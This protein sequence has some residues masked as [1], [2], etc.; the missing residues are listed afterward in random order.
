MGKNFIKFRRKVRTEA[1]ASSLLLG[2]GAG[3]FGYAVMAIVFKL[4]GRTLPTFWYAV[5]GGGAVLT[6]LILYFI[7]TPSDKRL[8]KRLDSVYSL[9]EKI[10]TMVEL[11]E[12]DDGFA[13]LQRE[14]AEEKLGEKPMRALKSKQ[15]IAGILVFAIAAG[16]LTGAVLV[17]AKAEAGEA[18]I[19]A[20]D[21]E[22][23][24]TTLNE[25]IS[26][27]EGS[28]IDDTLKATSLD[29]LRSLLAFVEESQLL[30]EMKAEAI[31][32]V[33]AINRALNTAN[34]AE[35]IGEQLLLSQDKNI[36]SLGKEMQELSGSGS[37]KALLTLGEAI[38]AASVQDASFTAEEIIT[39]IN[40]SGVRADD[41]LALMFK[42]LASVAK[43]NHAD[44]ADEFDTAGTKLSSA[45][46]IQKVNKST[47]SIVI[48]RLC[49]LFGITESDI[50]TVD[51]ESDIEIG[52]PSDDNDVPGDDTE[53]EEPD[54][55]IGSGGLGTGDVIYGSNDLIF[56]PYTNT[57]RPY[58][59]VINDY[60]AKANEQITDGKTSE[61]ITDAA[62]KYFDTLFSGTDKN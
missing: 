13:V 15:L 54:G 6:S 2:F 38:S 61:D 58:G 50:N 10:S 52:S 12:S 24:I 39:Y 23:I 7:F 1:I 48:T 31:K 33:I 51:P 62:E 5:F 42:T 4:C 26:I 18:E 16:S 45:L 36:V 20:F 9:D 25:L 59:E 49:N 22:W 57:Y 53:V 32:T 40:A 44:A 47:I 27:V 60:F 19:G 43:N 46:L 21:K 41:E 35:A 28:Y 11:R 56:D 37:K 34:S 17:P 29:E 3:V 30:S 55:G 8:A 14:D